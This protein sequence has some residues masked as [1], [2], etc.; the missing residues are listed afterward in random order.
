[1]QHATKPILVEVKGKQVVMLVPEIDGQLAIVHLSV[2]Q[3]LANMLKKASVPVIIE[4]FCELLMAGREGAKLEEYVKALEDE[5]AFHKTVNMLSEY[6][7]EVVEAGVNMPFE[8][9]YEDVF[10]LVRKADED[11]LRRYIANTPDTAYKHEVIDR[12][13]MTKREFSKDFR[14]WFT[15]TSMAMVSGRLTCWG[16]KP[17]VATVEEAPG[18]QTEDQF[19]TDFVSK[20][21]EEQ[22]DRL[23]AWDS[24]GNERVKQYYDWLVKNDLFEQTNPA[25]DSWFKGAGYEIPSSIH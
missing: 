23:G 3:R 11:E 7:P 6:K 14:E 2:I 16:T 1:M 21:V 12:L 18:V 20:P 13:M 8:E 17:Y 24:T 4:Q 15:E 25:I 10:E 22:L 19:F 5:L 9:M